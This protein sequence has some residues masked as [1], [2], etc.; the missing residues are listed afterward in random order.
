MSHI[1]VW[2]GVYHMLP[3][4]DANVGC[5][6]AVDRDDPKHNQERKHDKQIA[7]NRN[8][9]AGAMVALVAAAIAWRATQRQIEAQRKATDR[10]AAYSEMAVVNGRSQ[11]FEDR[12]RLIAR[13]LGGNV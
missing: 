2:A 12:L 6:E 10:A 3:F 5:G 13:A 9:V 4:F 8:Q 11:I 7:E 1:C